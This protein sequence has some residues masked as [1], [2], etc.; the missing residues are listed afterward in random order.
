MQARGFVSRWLARSLARS[1]AWM[2]SVAVLA[3]ALAPALA[4]AWRGEAAP[5]WVEVCSTLGARLVRADL[6]VYAPTDAAA[7]TP[8]DPAAPADHGVAHCPWCGGHAGAAGLPPAP[9]AALPALALAA[10]TPRRFL[11]A[12]RTAF[13]WVTAQPRAP[14]ARA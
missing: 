7:N 5:G 8:T 11:A 14:P 3:G 10:D 9:L 12:P 4:Q 6:G 2:V 1:L 13:V